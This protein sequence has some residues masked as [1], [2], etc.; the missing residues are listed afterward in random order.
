MQLLVP[1]SPHSKRQTPP[2][3][4]IMP[5]KRQ[6]IASGH[7]PTSLMPHINHNKHIRE[8]RLGLK[9]LWSEIIPALSEF[10][11]ILDKWLEESTEWSWTNVSQERR[12]KIKRLFNFVRRV[13]QSL[14]GTE[15]KEKETFLHPGFAEFLQDK[16]LS[17]EFN[18]NRFIWDDLRLDEANLKDLLNDSDDFSHSRLVYRA[19]TLFRLMAECVVRGLEEE[20]ENLF[21]VRVE[22]DRGDPGGYMEGL[23]RFLRRVLDEEKEEEEEGEGKKVSTKEEGEGV[24]GSSI[25]DEETL[26][27]ESVAAGEETLMNGIA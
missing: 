9:Q 6:K 13:K 12:S 7:A 24:E 18:D 25:G 1:P 2:T 10:T 11:L 8:R 21:D 26:V 27:E 22:F 23:L 14:E 16:G 15:G 20:T 4:P 17:K 19:F 5:T 3:S